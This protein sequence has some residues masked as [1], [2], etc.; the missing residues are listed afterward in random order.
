MSPHIQKDLV[1]CFAAVVVHLLSCVLPFVI[2]WT[3]A[4]QASLSFTISQS[5]FKFMSNE[6]MMPHNH[7]I[8]C[9]PLLLCPQSF[10]ASGSFP[11]YQLFASGVQSTGASASVSV[12]LMNI[13]GWFPLGLT[14]LVSLFPRDSQESSPTPQFESTNSLA[15]SLLYTPVLTSIHDSWKNHSFDYTVLCQ[16]SDIAAF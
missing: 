4:R 2:L 8:L 15:L 5:L 10:L 13:W 11:T 14:V 7:L 6:S 16:Q 9:R 12:L 3:I 1:T